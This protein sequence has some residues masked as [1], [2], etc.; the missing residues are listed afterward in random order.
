MNNLTQR[1]ITGSLFVAA[2]VLCIIWNEYSTALIFLVFSTLATVEFYQIL[3]KKELS[4]NTKYGPFV[5]VV[6]YTLL[7][8]VFIEE[9]KEYRIL[10]LIVPFLFI[11]VLQEL[12][13]KDNIPY[14]NISSTL[15]A[16]LYI[17]LPFACLNYLSFND[18][19]YS[20]IGLGENWSL[21]L[22]FFI[23]LWT[24][25]SMAYVVGKAI[26][27]HKLIPRISP[28][29]TWEGL[30][31]GLVFSILAGFLFAY[32]TDSSVF[33]WMIMA[34]IISIFGLLGD[35]SESL[36]KRSADVK[37]SGTLL[38]GHG[39]VLDRFD[40]ILFSAPLVL[41]YLLFI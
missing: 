40:G 5:N 38:P 16:L 7:S 8:L 19:I 31:G 37:D 12:F 17:T 33:H 18:D 39:G 1:I 3:N 21:L 27:K 34:A 24:S 4:N 6:V 29:K 23:I 20:K 22:G 9:I 11:F 36:L 25:D 14:Q 41:T 15:F 30:A 28:G 13:A 32:V 35:L 2:L 10:F 26:G